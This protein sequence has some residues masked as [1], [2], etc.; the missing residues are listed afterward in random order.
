MHEAFDPFADPNERAERHEL[1]DFSVEDLVRRVLAR[2][3]VPRI[4]LRLLERERDA[5]ALQVHVQ[6]FDG[7]F[8]TDLH[9]L[10]RVLDVLPRQLADVD[11]P[12][13]AAEVDERAEV[14]DRRD[15]ALLDLTLLEVLEEVLA[16]FRLRLFEVLP[17]RQHDV[18]AVAVELDDLALEL[19]A[20]EGV[21]VAHAP[22]VDEGRGKEAAQADVEDQPALHDFD[23]GAGDD[24][25]L[26]HDLLDLTPGP[27]VL[28]FL[29]R[30][31]QPAFFVFFLGD[32]RLDLLA[33]FHD[34]AGVDVVLDRELARGDHA[35]GLVADV[36]ED[37]VLV[38]PDDLPLHEVAVVEG[39]DGRFVGGK[40]LFLA[41]DVVLG[42]A[43]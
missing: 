33:D 15:R 34:L 29:D 35:F 17:A 20:D 4:L 13:D 9:D 19:L 5:L 28:G 21:Q 31:D 27:L 37:L 18:V 43:G 3:L 8:L 7:H 10:A 16:A 42:H 12:V 26:F 6:D 30:Q 14:H 40:E 39:L 24:P 1:R 38:D 11:Q 23:D 2:E 32:E 36:E 41:S 22:Q 25:V